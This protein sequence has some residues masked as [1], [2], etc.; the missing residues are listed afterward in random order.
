MLKRDEVDGL[1][2]SAVQT[3]SMPP[4]QIGQMLPGIA[5]AA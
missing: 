5:V 2:S 1:V 4:I 3:A